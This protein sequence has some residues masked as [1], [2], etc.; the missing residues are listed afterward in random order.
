MNLQTTR[1]FL[2]WFCLPALVLSIS[3][4]ATTPG[5]GINSLMNGAVE[6]RQEFDVDVV[7]EKN[8]GAVHQACLGT[9][10]ARGIRTEMLKDIS[11]KAMSVIRN[12]A[13]PRY[14]LLTAHLATCI[15]ET[16]KGF[17]VL[18]TEV[19]YKTVEPEGVPAP[20]LNQWYAEI[21]R[22]LAQAGQAEVAYKFPNG[23]AHRARYWSDLRFRGLLLYEA[24]FVPEKDFK[25]SN[26]DLVFT[27]PELKGV[28]TSQWASNSPDV[29]HRKPFLH[30][31]FV[32][33]EKKT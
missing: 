6:I 20:T 15:E 16:S 17:P 22:T 24:T 14:L 27:H 12:T 23:N 26:F 8:L 11:N 29:Y 32:T 33:L 4:C 3:A 19:F 13:Q 18:A 25:A 7:G 28:V 30:H 31:R 2:T 1:K 10:L 5:K 9:Q 21:A